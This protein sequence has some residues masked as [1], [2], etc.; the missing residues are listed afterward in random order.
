MQG[1]ALR[2]PHTI[3]LSCGAIV[4]PSLTLS[5]APPPSHPQTHPP[6]LM[7]RCTESL[8][9]VRSLPCTLHPTPDTPHP[10]PHT[11]HPTPHTPHPS[12][13]TPHPTLSAPHPNPRAGRC[14]SQ[15][16]SRWTAR[17]RRK[18]EQSPAI[19]SRCS[20]AI[21]MS[22]RRQGT[23]LPREGRVC[24]KRLGLGVSNVDW[25][26]TFDFVVKA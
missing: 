3:S 2:C 9:S 24:V 25:T 23:L 13:H 6:F 8:P 5:V 7:E 19:R 15:Q 22:C 17:P 10:T 4:W 21:L 16:R 11:R 1:L 12:P 20:C 26:T 18:R 14:Q